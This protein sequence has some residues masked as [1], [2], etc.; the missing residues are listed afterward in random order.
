METV[1]G[2]PLEIPP[3]W[4]VSRICEEFGCL[5]SAALMELEHDAALVADIIELRAFARS[6][7]RVDEDGDKLKITPMVKKVLTIEADIMK[8]RIRGR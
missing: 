1:D 6:K 3:E 2:V 8:A 4:I 5:P 7:T